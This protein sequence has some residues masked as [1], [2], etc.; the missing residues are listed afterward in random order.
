MAQPKNDGSGFGSGFK[1]LSRNQDFGKKLALKRSEKGFSQQQLAS[2]LGSGVKTIQRYEAGELPKGDYLL[3][4]SDILGCSIDWLLKGG[5]SEE[6]SKNTKSLEPPV[7]AKES[8]IDNLLMQEALGFGEGVEMLAKIFA[9]KN[10]VLIRAI[11]ANLLA[12]SE[13]VDAKITIDQMKKDEKARDDRMAEM[14]RRMDEQAAR[15]DT[16]D[17]RQ[18]ELDTENKTLK[19]KI[20][21]LQ[22][23]LADRGGGLPDAVN[24]R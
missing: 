20:G 3:S 15:M 5:I 22:Q 23:Q 4:L 16:Q 8:L 13:T 21:E 1:K 19:R 12:F 14:E 24:H 6:A 2:L 11:S 9:S 17:S 7:E 10:Q 18:G